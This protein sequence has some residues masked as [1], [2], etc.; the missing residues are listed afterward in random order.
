MRRPLAETKNARVEGWGDAGIPQPGVVAQRS[1][2]LDPFDS[3]F[4]NLGDADSVHLRRRRSWRRPPT[5]SIR[6]P[7]DGPCRRARGRPRRR[8]LGRLVQLVLKITDLV[9]GGVSHRGI[10]RSLLPL[11]A[12]GTAGAFAR[13]GLCCPCRQRSDAPIRRPHP[14]PCRLGATSR[15][16]GY[17]HRLLLA[18]APPGPATASPVAVPTV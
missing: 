8:P 16:A 7:G 9:E 3:A 5:L 18:I 2:R 4:F 10:H 15:C 14:T 17:T 11:Q 12:R 13:T 6:S 1:E